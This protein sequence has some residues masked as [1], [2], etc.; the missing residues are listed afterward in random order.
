MEQLQRETTLCVQLG[1]GAVTWRRKRQPAEG[2]RT[3]SLEPAVS[4]VGVRRSREEGP[5][6]PAP[7]VS[8]GAARPKEPFRSIAEVGGAKGAESFILGL[9][10]QLRTSLVSETAVSR[11]V[12]GLYL[13]TEDKNEEETR[14]R[15]RVRKEKNFDNWLAALRIMACIIVEKFP[16]CPKD[17]WLFESKINEAQRQ[18]A[19]DAWIDYNNG[20]RLRMQTRLD[21][22]WDEED[23]AGYMHKMMIARAAKSWAG[24][25]EYSFHGNYHKG[26]HEKAKP[27]YILQQYTQWKGKQTGKGATVVCFKYDKD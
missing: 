7:T 16:H 2:G 22:E 27:F 24:K 12:E 14:E 3:A 17:S 1:R 23:V 18:F 19:G 26:S 11:K 4:C 5:V 6:E 21:M 8:R 20:F 10:Q 13:T 15:N 9:R 25:S